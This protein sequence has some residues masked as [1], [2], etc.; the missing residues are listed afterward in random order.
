MPSDPRS[1]AF[2]QGTRT[3]LFSGCSWVVESRAAGRGS[4]PAPRRAVAAARQ[5]ATV[6]PSAPARPAAGPPDRPPAFDRL[7]LNCPTSPRAPARLSGWQPDH[8]LDRRPANPPARGP[9]NPPAR[10]FDE[11]ACRPSRDTPHLLPC[12]STDAPFC[13]LS[14]RNP[15]PLAPVSLLFS[16][17]SPRA[18]TGS[19]QPPPPSGPQLPRPTFAPTAQLTGT[20][21]RGAEGGRDEARGGQVAL[22]RLSLS[23]RWREVPMPDA[24]RR[25]RLFPSHTFGSSATA[26]MS[27]TTPHCPPPPPTTTPTLEPLE[28][29]SDGVSRRRTWRSCPGVARRGGAVSGDTAATAADEACRRGCDDRYAPR[30]V[31]ATTARWQR[32]A[33]ACVDASVGRGS[34]RRDGARG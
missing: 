8:A 20:R 28:P 34:S 23:E 24:S 15:P 18:S 19:S 29:Y 1:W 30:L 27:A 3:R 4:R 32:R 6:P 12:P 26:I 16:V 14:P 10:L 21:C 33:G 25:P 13:A 7:P 11:P 9:A 5:P 17:V 2:K 22:F 31:S